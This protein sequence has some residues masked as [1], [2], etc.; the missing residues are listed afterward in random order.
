M[1][2]PTIGVIGK[3]RITEEEY[4]LLVTLGKV[5]ARAGKSLI[6]VPAEGTAK[7]VQV[8]VSLEGGVTIEIAKDVLGQSAHAFVYADERLV[9][10][11]RQLDP[12]I[13][14]RRNVTL[15]FSPLEIELW[16]DAAKTI[17]KEKGLEFPQ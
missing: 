3:T 9:E 17:F 10:R 1:K 6:I 7:A 4:D 8:G 14:Q 16:L 13:T 15:L 12:N 2:V 5:I 11:L